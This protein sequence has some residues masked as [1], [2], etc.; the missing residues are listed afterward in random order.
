MRKF[1]LFDP[2]EIP[3]LVRSWRP[4]IEPQATPEDTHLLALKAKWFDEVAI[5]FGLELKRQQKENNNG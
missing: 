4:T 3:D 1:N 5:M 2:R